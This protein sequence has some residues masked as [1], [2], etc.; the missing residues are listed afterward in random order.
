M[1]KAIL[2]VLGRDRPGIV[3]AVA[4][5]LL[6]LD[7]NIENVSQAMLQTEFA[8]IFLVAM[9][10]SVTLRRLEATLAARLE[11]LGLQIVAKPCASAAEEETPPPSE[12][13][14]ITSR[15]PDRKG[16]VAHVSEVIARH[17][18][19]ITRLQAVFKGGSQPGDNLMIF[20][21]DVPEAVDAG[22]LRRELNAAAEQLGLEIN[23]QHRFIF[24]TLHRI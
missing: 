7:C 18:V 11:P 12:P 1:K 15:G 8:G 22:A 19:N 13:F 14:V 16:L 2:S 6:E 23:L 17:G 20:E 3:A 24:E 10:E 9:P 5:G 21:V 4:R